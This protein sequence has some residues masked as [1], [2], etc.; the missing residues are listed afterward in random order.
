MRNAK[1]VCTLGPASE[2]RATIRELAEA[3]MR[4]ARLNAS[5]GTSED[6]ADLIERVRAVDAAIEA[7]LAVMVDLQGP[8]VRTADIDG[9][10]ALATGS[11]VAFEPGETASA[12]RVGL[13]HS[14]AAA[15]AGDV[16]LLD[17]GRIECTVAAVDGETVTATVDSG[18]PLSARKGVNV[19]GVELDV[20]LITEAD[21]RDIRLAAEAEADFVAASFVR[22]AGDVFDIRDRLERY[23][24]GDVP[25]VSKIERAG[26]VE[27]LDGIVDTSYGVMVARGDLGVEC[28][29]ED[30]PMIQKRIISRS[31]EAGVPVITATEMLDS[32]VEARRPTRAEASDVAN[33]VLDGTDAVMLSGETAVGDHPVRVVETMARIVREVEA[34][35]EYAETQEHGVPKAAAESRTEALARSARY[36]ARDVDAAAVVAASESGFT[37]RKTAKFRPGVPVVATTPDDRVRRQLALSWGV[38]AQYADYADTAEEVLDNAVDAALDA[39][40][41]DSGDTIVVLSGMMTQLEGTNTTNML[42]VHVAAESVATGRSVVSGRTVGPLARA[43]DGDLSAVPEGAVVALSAAFEGEFVGDIERL[44]GIVDAREGL[45]GYPAMV[46]RETGVPM[47]SDAAVNDAVAD[48]ETVTL[49]ATRGV[50]YEGRVTGETPRR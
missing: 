32:M 8:E 1:I 25:V 14:I 23:G 27:N 26:A 47:V 38:D 4:V 22:D 33:A 42:K 19:P 40:V 21:D 2:D 17:D 16:V 6:R 46:A 31:K 15:E 9:E 50:L 35:E 45:T 39:G 49:D 48:G 44:G 34:S 30:V 20:D 28:P 7:P 3:G 11:T 41:A 36:L 37:A 10:V 29:L 13:S 12:E 24:G 18:G 5:H 43:D